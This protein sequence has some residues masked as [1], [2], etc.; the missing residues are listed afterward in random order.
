MV[1]YDWLSNWD[2]NDMTRVP[3]SWKYHQEDRSYLLRLTEY[4]GEVSDESSLTKFTLYRIKWCPRS[5]ERQF[6]SKYLGFIIN[7]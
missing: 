4:I 6:D 3:D 5:T 7:F 1:I 2:G